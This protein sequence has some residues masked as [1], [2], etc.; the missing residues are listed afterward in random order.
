[1]ESNAADLVASAG[2]KMI[3][4]TNFFYCRQ[5]FDNTCFL[6]AIFVIRLDIS[7]RYEVCETRGMQLPY[8]TVTAC[9]QLA[10]NSVS[11]KTR[12]KVVHNAEIR[13]GCRNVLLY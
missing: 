1:M 4:P 3:F 13:S 10:E 2:F 6:H 12:E 5:V 8:L 9:S 7:D 11:Q